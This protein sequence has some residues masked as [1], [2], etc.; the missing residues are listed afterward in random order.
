MTKGPLKKKKKTNEKNEAQ[1][2]G[3]GQEC[4]FKDGVTQITHLHILV[5]FFFH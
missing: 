5:S 4:V 2:R 3:R 1:K